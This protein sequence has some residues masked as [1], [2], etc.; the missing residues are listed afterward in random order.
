MALK[1]DVF[2]QK[3]EVIFYFWFIFVTVKISN[4]RERHRDQSYFYGHLSGLFTFLRKRVKLVL[5]GLDYPQ[6]LVA[7]INTLSSCCWEEIFIKKSS[8]QFYCSVGRLL[9]PTAFSSK[10]LS[11]FTD[12]DVPCFCWIRIALHPKIRFSLK[13]ECW[14][15]GKGRGMQAIFHKNTLVVI[16]LSHEYCS[17]T[18]RSRQ[19]SESLWMC[20]AVLV[21]IT[22]HCGGLILDGR[23]G[24]DMQ[25][26]M[27]KM[28]PY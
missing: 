22:W 11:P 16:A 14:T 20:G 19:G 21:K 4:L 18:S 5:P 23:D 17:L 28:S 27:Q 3:N 2:S 10:V 7:C 26:V 9:T 6:C 12:G 24:F 25:R 13:L 1:I 8:E 15:P